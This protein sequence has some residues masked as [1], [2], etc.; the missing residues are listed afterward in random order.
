MGHLVHRREELERSTGAAE[1]D[2]SDAR[3]QA[4][5]ARTQLRELTAEVDSA[6]RQLRSALVMCSC[7]AMSHELCHSFRQG[8]GPLACLMCQ[9]WA[10][11]DQ[12]GE[13]R[14]AGVPGA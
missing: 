8:L 1:R 9:A 11:G 13:G 5:A 7:M 10:Q 2:A 4:D 3:A 12:P 14:P 6:R